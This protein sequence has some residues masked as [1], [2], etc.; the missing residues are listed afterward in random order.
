MTTPSG[1]P[2]PAPYPP[3]VHPRQRVP[4]HKNATIKAAPPLRPKSLDPR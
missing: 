2:T 3:P 1:R 4:S